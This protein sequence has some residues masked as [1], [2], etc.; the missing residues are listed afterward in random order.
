MDG[1]LRESLRRT[2]E[3]WPE[4]LRPLPRWVHEIAGLSDVESTAPPEPRIA[5][6]DLS[7]RELA[8]ISRAIFR[9]RI[10]RPEDE[11]ELASHLDPKI[12]LARIRLRRNVPPA[13]T[14]Q[15]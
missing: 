7:D 13:G 12:S 2:I 8:Y 4:R 14:S 1:I 3:T 6:E 15:G 9:Q 5:L 11:P 10:D